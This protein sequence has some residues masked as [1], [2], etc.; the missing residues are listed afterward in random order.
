MVPQKQQTQIFWYAVFS[1]AA[2]VVRHFTKEQEVSIVATE[3]QRECPAEQISHISEEDARI[4]QFIHE[5][6]YGKVV[7]TVRDGKAVHAE[8]QRSV[9][10][11]KADRN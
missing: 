9:P 5:L 10:L 11:D 8:I 7:I 3:N 2:C 6:S 4:L 1:Y